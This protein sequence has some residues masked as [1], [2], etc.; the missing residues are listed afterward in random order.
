MQELAYVTPE[1]FMNR[2]F[3]QIKNLITPAND[4]INL[5]CSALKSLDF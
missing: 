2:I 5:E 3:T 4:V 1:F